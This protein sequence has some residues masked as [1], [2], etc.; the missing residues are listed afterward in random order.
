[1]RRL[2]SR[3]PVMLLSDAAGDPGSQ[4]PTHADSRRNGARSAAAFALAADLSGVVVEAAALL[5][6]P[7]LLAELRATGL[8][9]A[10]WGDANCDPAA[11]AA[12]ARAGVCGI[13]T[14]A[15]S[16]AAE[17]LDS[18]FGPPPPLPSPCAANAGS[19]LLRNSVRSLPDFLG[20]DGG[21]PDTLLRQHPLANL[22]FSGHGGSVSA[23]F[24]ADGA[25]AVRQMPLPEDRLAG[26]RVLS[27][28][29]AA[30]QPACVCRPGMA[31]ASCRFGTGRPSSRLSAAA[32][33]AAAGRP[34]EGRAQL[35]PAQLAAL[36]PEAGFGR[37][38]A[39]P[40]ARGL[41]PG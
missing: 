12:Q 3:W 37:G 33:A 7:A 11:V 29:L 13:I 38:G 5:A 17:A 31:C 15:L 1:M 9:V 8:L 30:P 21:V 26:Q 35:T 36:S 28:A 4:W 16:T 2:T 25:V 32:A 39:S 41:W 14:D 27:A 22:R 19:P 10:S 20:G 18:V 23:A 40:K 6:S 34:G 24:C